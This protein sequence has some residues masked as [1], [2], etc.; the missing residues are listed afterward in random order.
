MAHVSRVPRLIALGLFVGLVGPARA[1]HTTFSSSVDR[2]EI[3]GNVFGQADGT[4]DSVDEFDDANLAPDWSV[5]RGT[6]EEAGGV[7]TMHD[8]GTDVVI[9]QVNVDTS[10]IENEQ[11]VEPGAGNF[12][13]TSYWVP[14]LPGSDEEFHFQFYGVGS[15]VIESAGLQLTNMSAESAAA[16]SPPGIAGYAVSQV[17]ARIGDSNSR[18]DSVA[19]TPA[20]VTGRI[21]FRVSYDDT[22][23]LLTSSFSLDGGTTFQSPFPPVPIFQGV[24]DSEILLGAGAVMPP[25]PSPTCSLVTTIE[26]GSLRTVGR[27]SLRGRVIAPP[28]LPASLNPIGQGASATIIEPFRT[29]EIRIP[30]GARGAG[31]CSLLD[32]WTGTGRRFRYRNVSN[33]LPPDCTPFSAHGLRD[34]A[35][36]DSRV[37][38]G[39]IGVKIS[40]NGSLGPPPSGAVHAFVVLGR[41][42]D[43]GGACAHADF[44]CDGVDRTCQ[45]R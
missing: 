21:V 37:S 16:Q 36:K 14:T 3:D 31:G 18:T 41:E 11:A 8:P 24:P 28:N 6:A 33:A 43:D 17:L 38:R 30:P 42:G 12:T 1:S 20:S 40:H 10:T 44:F 45:R 39:E 35:I 9:G 13:A 15:S 19:I 25:S 26:K 5:L 22:T 7:A 32:G 23:Q 4:L 29:V 2:F 27:F 34:V